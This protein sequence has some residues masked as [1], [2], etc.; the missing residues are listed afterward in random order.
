MIEP[1][2]SKWVETWDKEHSHK[3]KETSTG[4]YPAT[5][6]SSGQRSKSAKTILSLEFHINGKRLST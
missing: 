5:D 6:Q 2:I 3:W 4:L 1:E